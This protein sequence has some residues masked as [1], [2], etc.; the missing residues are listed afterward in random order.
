MPCARTSAL[1]CARTGAPR[2]LRR[3]RMREL[4]LRGHAPCYK[5]CGHARLCC[6]TSGHAQG[7]GLCASSV[8]ALDIGPFG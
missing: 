7:V 6:K 3:T 4:S 2:R 5:T 1:P 8:L